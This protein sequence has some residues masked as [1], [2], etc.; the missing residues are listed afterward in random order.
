MKNLSRL[1]HAAWCMILLM[2]FSAGVSAQSTVLTGK[3]L[4]TKHPALN[5]SFADYE[6]FELDFALNRNS[7]A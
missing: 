1:S 2:A 4:S 5:E 3:K 7:A 6:V